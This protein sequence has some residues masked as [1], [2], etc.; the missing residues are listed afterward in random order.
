MLATCHQHL[1]NNFYDI[2]RSIAGAT[3]T[4]LA[5]FLVKF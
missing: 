1:A 3:T 4:P 5:T 2:N